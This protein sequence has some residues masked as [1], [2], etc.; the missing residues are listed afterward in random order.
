MIVGLFAGILKRFKHFTHMLGKR[1]RNLQRF[2]CLHYICQILQ[3][4]VN[5]SAGF[6]V[7]FHDHR[8]LRVE[9]GAARQTAANRL[10]HFFNINT[11]LR[12]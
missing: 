6:K 5:A 11:G 9:N 2:G 3:I 1:K 8:H 10:V 12:C 4:N 7:A